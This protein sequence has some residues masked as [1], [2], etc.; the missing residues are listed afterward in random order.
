MQIYWLNLNLF[1]TYDG[2]IQKK[3]K[4]LSYITFCPIQKATG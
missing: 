1:G 3:F 4:S 2:Q